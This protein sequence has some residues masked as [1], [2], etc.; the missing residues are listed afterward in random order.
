MRSLF[1]FC[2]FSFIFCLLIFISFL[3][4][5]SFIFRFLFYVFFYFFF[6]FVLF[7][8]IWENQLNER[9]T[10]NNFQMSNN[11]LAFNKYVL[12]LNRIVVQFSTYRRTIYYKIYLRVKVNIKE[13]KINGTLTLIMCVLFDLKATIG[14]IID[15]YLTFAN[16][17]VSANW[18]LKK[19][20][21]RT[22]NNNSVDPINQRFFYVH[23]LIMYLHEENHS[24]LKTLRMRHTHKK[25]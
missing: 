5:F 11:Q 25:K 18:K 21:N 20:N 15:M 16:N 4:S 3:R 10:H 24:T 1:S 12:L 8:L 13:N 17:N 6:L 22:N 9:A 2:Y 23:K 14:L 7:L 19:V